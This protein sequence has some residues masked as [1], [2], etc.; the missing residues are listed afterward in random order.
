MHGS[1]RHPRLMS[2]C[3]PDPH[4]LRADLLEDEDF[5]PV[6]SRCSPA[7]DAARDPPRPAK[8]NAFAMLMGVKRACRTHALPVLAARQA[9][10]GVT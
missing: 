8:G 5:Q 10:L 2:V 1:R 7:L 9:S 4:P 6:L 3:T